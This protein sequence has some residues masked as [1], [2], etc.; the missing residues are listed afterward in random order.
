MDINDLKTINIFANL[1]NE[2]LQKVLTISH[3]EEYYDKNMLF[4]EDDPTQYFYALLKGGIKVYKM[5]TNNNEIVIH[6][7]V[8]PNLIAEMASLKSSTYPVNA[9]I[10]KDNTQI[11]AIKK[12]EFITLLK[13]NTQISFNMIES[14]SNKI[15]NLQ[16]TINRN[17]VLNSTQKLCSYLEENPN[18]LNEYK[19][20]EIANILNMAPETLSRIIQKLKKM[21]ILDNNR[22]VI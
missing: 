8:K 21:S 5:D 18:A 1:T 19:H 20:K 15:E 2:D 9:M 16:S 11:I 4:Y 22:V 14:L 3:I 17:M 12:E 13:T 7:F 6:Y 10:I